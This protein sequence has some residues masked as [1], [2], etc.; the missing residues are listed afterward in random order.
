ML[1]QAPSAI[2]E[3]QGRL[4]PGLKWLFAG[5]G[6][7][8]GYAY[9]IQH[10]GAVASCVVAGAAL[11]FIVITCLFAGLRLLKF[12]AIVIILLAVLNYAVLVPFGYGDHSE[13]WA[14]GIGRGCSAV[15]HGVARLVDQ[16]V[17]GL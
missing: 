11:G 3:M 16:W 6:G 1:S 8:G 15:W 13:D 17:A 10:G 14:I 7:A 5:A 2:D 9:A 12:A 4:P